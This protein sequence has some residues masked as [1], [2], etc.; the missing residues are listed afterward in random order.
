MI[1]WVRPKFHSDARKHTFKEGDARNTH[2]LHP[3]CLGEKTPHDP[4][5][6]RVPEIALDF[7]AGGPGGTGTVNYTHSYRHI[8]T[9]FT[10][11]H[12]Q[13]VYGAHPY[14]ETLIHYIYSRVG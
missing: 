9:L 13:C 14:Q 3:G 4:P 5:I 11:T 8:R 10:Y 2:T 1:Q 7:T 12:K 6:T